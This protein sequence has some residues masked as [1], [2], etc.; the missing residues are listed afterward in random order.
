MSTTKSKC[1]DEQVDASFEEYKARTRTRVKA[2]M[3]AGDPARRTFGVIALMMMLSTA[4]F[5]LAAAFAANGFVTSVMVLAL[6]VVY[7]PVQLHLQK[8]MFATRVRRQV[9]ASAVQVGALVL[10]SLLA[11]SPVVTTLAV[12]VMVVEVAG[13]AI[14]IKN[15]SHLTGRD[16][17]TGKWL[18]QS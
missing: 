8:A 17:R 9:L 1:S 11:S 6:G 5:F 18:D 3:L 10:V 16:L 13:Q 7:W 4:V 15:Y 12:L 2:Q 14:Y